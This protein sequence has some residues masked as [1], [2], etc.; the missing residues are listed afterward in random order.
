M[1]KGKFSI[2]AKISKVQKYAIL[3]LSSQNHSIENI[4]KELGL[5]EKQISTIVNK[6]EQQKPSIQTTKSSV[7]SSRS[8]NLMIRETAGKR[9]KSVA[10]MTKEASMLNDDYKNK[11]PVD[12][13]KN[14]DKYIYRPNK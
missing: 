14:T 9:T 7:S 4:S 10:I 12:Q 1:R 13:Q 6:S 11:I 8:Q 3:W 5:N 2:M